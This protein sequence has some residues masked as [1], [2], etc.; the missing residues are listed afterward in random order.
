MLP[1]NLKE[2]PGKEVKEIMKRILLVLT[3]ALMMAAMMMASAIPAFAVNPD[4]Q[5]RQFQKDANCKKGEFV[6]LAF[7]NQGPCVAHINVLFP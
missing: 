7:D 2:V 5:E 6:E 1:S 3:V 4:N